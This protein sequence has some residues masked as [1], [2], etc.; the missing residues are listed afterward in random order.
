[1]RQPD[2]CVT[3]PAASGVAASI[4]D[5]L[6]RATNACRRTSDASW[7]FH[8]PGS[9]RGARLRIDGEWLY[10]NAPLRALPRP[11]DGRLIETSLRRNA[12]IA[13]PAR[14]VGSDLSRERCVV[15]ELPTE[16]LPADR[17]PDLHDLIA[18]L[19]S[20]L[21][22]ALDSSRCYEDVDSP[23]DTPLCGDRLASVFD[24]AERP[25][26]ATGGDRQCVPFDVAGAYFAAELA[27]RQS[28]LELSVPLYADEYRAAPADCRD[29]FRALLWLTGN[30][31][32]MVRASLRARRPKI[33]VTLAHGLIEP[34]AVAHA[35]A[36]LAATL[37][38]FAREAAL[39]LAD[40]SLARLFLD[41]LE[42]KPM[43]R[44]TSPRAV[45]P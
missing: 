8:L 1:M 27:S 39:L 5:F 14:L 16:L 33:A 43:A 42:I 40:E 44:V 4:G 32:Q 36:A 26:R 18:T 45:V 9:R 23:G 30:R 15:V 6:A 17:E 13:G 35:C 31:T 21:D 2:P 7:Q 19:L 22:R 38:R 29:A 12:A 34:A 24:Q 41:L 10:I 3:G 11:V 25:L 37:D 20:S 28:G